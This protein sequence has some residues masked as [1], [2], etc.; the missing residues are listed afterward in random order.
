[1][2]FFS[3]VGPNKPELHYCIPALER[4]DLD[5]VLRLVREQKYFVPHAPR[6]TGQTSILLA[7]Q[8]NGQGYHCLYATVEGAGASDEGA[9]KTTRTVLA[10]LAYEARDEL[11]DPFL[12]EVWPGVLAES[13]PDQA[14]MEALERWSRASPKP[15]L[16]LIDEIDALQGGSLLSALR[17]LRAG[18]RKRPA[19][20]PQSV[21]LCGTCAT[22]AWTR[23]AAPST[24]SRSCCAWATSAGRRRWRCSASIPPGRGRR[25]RPRRRRRCGSRPLASRGW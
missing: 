24:S 20:F 22:T 4:L 7:L 5:E 12:A 18:Y 16:L 13:D 25:S 9:E 17:Q 19:A 2:R 8:G 1:M 21:V 11:D 15:L 23:P 10:S 6:Q 14:L 3:T